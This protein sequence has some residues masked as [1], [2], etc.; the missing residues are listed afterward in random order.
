MKIV[1]SK[2]FIK[3]AKLTPKSIQNKL[4]DLLEILEKDPFHPLI[5]TKPLSGDLKGFYSFRVT[6][7]WRVIFD[8]IENSQVIFLVGG[9][10]RKDIYK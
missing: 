4:A 9:A 2:E 6:R 5:H 8:F 10:H 1:Y 7:D 3:S